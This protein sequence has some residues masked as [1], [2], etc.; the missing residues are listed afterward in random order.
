MEQLIIRIL[1]RSMLVLAGGFGA[2]L[3]TNAGLLHTTFCSG[4]GYEIQEVEE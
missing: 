4:T 2:W 3:A 1:G